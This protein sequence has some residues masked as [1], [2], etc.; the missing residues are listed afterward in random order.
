MFYSIWPF[1]YARSTMNT[2]TSILK[3]YKGTSP[4]I[5]NACFI[6]ENTSI[7]GDVAIGQGTSVWYGTTIRGDV[8]IIRIGEDTNVQDGTV[9]HVAT[10]GNGTHIG[11]R[12]TIGHQALLHDCTIHDEAYIGMQS[13]I[14]DG[15]VVESRALVAAG[16]L[17]TAGKTIP[18]GQ[19]WAGRPA[20]YMRDLNED[21][22]KL[23]DW[24]WKHYKT[25][26]E[27][28]KKA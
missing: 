13:C 1:F 2:M 21:D 24:S 8:N 22:Y 4:Q 20:K 16:S 18:T 3:P 23:I 15:A 12:V 11:D 14:M 7:I 6:A 9:I 10:F 5:D 17:V 28:H 27:K 19:L 25:V 26:A